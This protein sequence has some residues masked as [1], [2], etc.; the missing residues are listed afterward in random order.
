MERMDLASRLDRLRGGCS[1]PASVPAIEQAVD[2]PAT[3]LRGGM[4]ALAKALRGDVISDGLVVSESRHR[5]DMTQADLAGLSN[6]PET[7]DEPATDWVYID[8]ETTG[9][10]GGVGTLAFMVGIARYLPDGMLSVR[11]YTMSRFSGEALMLRD[12]TAWIGESATLC[13]YNGRCFDLPLL[14]NRLR[15]QRQRCAI[16]SLSHLDLMYG[17]RRAYRQQWQDCRLQ[18]AEKRRLGIQRVDDMPGALAPQAWQ[19]WLGDA[20]P[21][22]LIE[23]LAHNRQDVVS[24]A[25]LHLALVRDHADAAHPESDPGAIGLA[26]YR[27]GCVDRAMALWERHADRLDT[28]AALQ[29]A[30]AYRRA[31]R[32]QEAESVWLRLHEQGNRDAALALSK[33]YEHRLRDYPQAMR[34]ALAC[35]ESDEGARTER[36]RRK[37]GAAQSAGPSTM[38]NLEL[39]LVPRPIQDHRNFNRSPRI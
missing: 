3:L 34:F 1:S 23:V 26:W 33:Y 32:W 5:L 14:T 13:S 11:Q 39:P 28:S 38:G 12:L 2:H 16:A 9:L 7:Y 27:V 18:T 20:D 35:G 30:A 25:R 29:Q 10:S 37:L 8:T 22:M 21:S 24:L 15:L 4:G 19:R 17:V 6:L 31:E 36:L